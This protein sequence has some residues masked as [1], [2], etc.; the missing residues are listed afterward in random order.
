MIASGVVA[1]LT[2]RMVPWVAFGVSATGS[3][4]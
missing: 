4:E 2:I 1:V 3:G